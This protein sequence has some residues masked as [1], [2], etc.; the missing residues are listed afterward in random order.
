MILQSMFRDATLA[1]PEARGGIGAA[2]SWSQLK[3]SGSCSSVPA[4]NSDVP[5]RCAK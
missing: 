2:Y 4:L 3:V 5:T 1:N